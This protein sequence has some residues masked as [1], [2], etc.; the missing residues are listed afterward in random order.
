MKCEG[1][2]Q[3]RRED[4]LNALYVAL[5]RSQKHLFLCPK[6]AEFMKQQHEKRPELSFNTVKRASRR[7][8]RQEWK[9]KWAFFKEDS[10]R[11]EGVD[12]IPWPIEFF[13][14]DANEDPQ[15]L[16]DS[17]MNENKQR[18]FLRT[19]M[20]NFHPDKFLPRFQDRFVDDA[21]VHESIQN[22]LYVVYDFIFSALRDLSNAG[23][24]A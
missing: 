4:E 17:E 14:D 20:L 15:L 11:V 2:S 3:A 6:A 23:E 12:D 1:I 10:A 21:N 16:L 19:L 5:T 22:R 24:D 8:Q 7:N 18:H 9:N 13:E